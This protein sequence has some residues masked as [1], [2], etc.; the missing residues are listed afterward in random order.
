MRAWLESHFSIM[1]T[2]K[3]H[4]L[5][6]A[7]V[8]GL[9]LSSVRPLQAESAFTPLFN[10]KDFTGWFGRD[11][12]DP[13]KLW[14]MTLEERTALSKK[15]MEDPKKGILAHWKVEDGL[16]AN[17]GHG[18][19]LTTEE[20]YGDFELK[21]DY[22]TGKGSDSGIY[23]RGCPQVQI[24]D[25]EAADPNGHGNAKGSG[26]LWNNSKGAP[27]KDPTTKA[28]KP[29]GE[30]NSFR[31]K[32]IGER[33]T[34]VLNDQKVV[35]NAVLENYFDRKRPVFPKGPVQL[36]T[37]GAPIW[38]RN[39]ELRPIGYEEMVK[40]LVGEEAGFTPL[41]NGKDFSGWK[42]ATDSYE[43]VSMRTTWCGWSS[44]SR[45]KAITAS[46]STIRGKAMPPMRP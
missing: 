35:D 13:S 8:L 36:Q 41:F 9:S 6:T 37:H 26:G 4:Y 33:V 12:E 3:P 40:H 15:T 20:H 28:D 27:G 18:L 38:W 43:V 7:L 5:T 11:T 30:W 23:L 32:M 21:V 34:V 44:N 14:K 39:V 46:P 19:Y 42:G 31:I 16:L 1:T 10:G 2:P 22:K 45:L 24:W 17:D 25:P 29:M